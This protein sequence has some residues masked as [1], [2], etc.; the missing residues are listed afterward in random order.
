M[1]DYLTGDAYERARTWLADIG[2]PDADDPDVLEWLIE[3]S[4]PG[5]LHGFICTHLVNSP[6]N[7]E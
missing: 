3:T 2:L 7:F 4:Y 5:G 1:A 6:E